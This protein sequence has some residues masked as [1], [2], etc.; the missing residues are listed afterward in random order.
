MCNN[1]NLEI[2]GSIIA[3]N[4]I[5]GDIYCKVLFLLSIYDLLFLHTSINIATLYD[6]RNLLARLKMNLR[7]LS[8]ILLI[9]FSGARQ[10]SPIM[11][12]GKFA[13]P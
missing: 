10:E 4:A 12:G 2:T 11:G 3:V 1:N 6:F 8:I 9:V 13:S 5:P 7:F